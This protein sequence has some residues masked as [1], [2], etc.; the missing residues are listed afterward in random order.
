MDIN[1]LNEVNK[2]GKTF[3]KY[4]KRVQDDSTPWTEMEIRY[5]RKYLRENPSK[6][7]ILMNL[8]KDEYSITSEQTKKGIEYITKVCFKKNGELRKTKYMPF[9]TREARIIRDFKEFKFVGL[10]NTGSH[11][12][13][14]YLPV[15]RVV[16]K[17]REYFEYTAGIWGNMEV[18]G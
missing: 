6:Y 2:P 3:N 7:S 17:N 10:Y 8:F 5:F 4:L 12:N 18:I 1:C 14:F 9:G 15:Y 13:N 16:S 11:Y